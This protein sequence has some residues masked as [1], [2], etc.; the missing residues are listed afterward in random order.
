VNLK[1]KVLFGVFL[2]FLNLAAWQKDGSPIAT[3]PGDQTEPRVAIFGKDFVV[4]YQ[5]W[6]YP[7]YPKLRAAMVNGETGEKIWDVSVADDTSSQGAHQI[8][9]D[10]NGMTWI[11]FERTIAYPPVIGLQKLNSNGEK[12]FGEAGIN[13]SSDLKKKKN[14]QLCLDGSGEGCYV[15]WTDYR[16]GSRDVWA[17]RVAG[18]GQ[19]VWEKRVGNGGLGEIIASGNNAIIAGYRVWK[20]DSMG[21]FLWDSLGVSVAD[22]T[23]GI[24]FPISDEKQGVIV[25]FQDESLSLRVQR[26]DSTGERRWGNNG[27]VLQTWL[28]I[29]GFG[30]SQLVQESDFGFSKDGCGGCLVSSYKGIPTKHLVYRVDSSGIIVWPSGVDVWVYPG[31]DVG[32]SSPSRITYDNLGGCIATWSVHSDST[33]GYPG[34]IVAQRVDKE[35]HIRF[36]ENGLSLCSDSADQRNPVIISVSGG[37][38]LYW[39]D[40]RNGNTDI[41]AQF[42]DTL[43]NVGLE[44]RD[45]PKQSA[46][47]LS[48]NPN[49]FMKEVSVFYTIPQSSWFKLDIFDVAGRRVRVLEEG[50]K[51]AGIYRIRWNRKTEKGEIL[52]AGIYF[53]RLS[54]ETKVITNKLVVLG[55]KGV[56]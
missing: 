27:V 31:G 9:I 39:K 24:S 32:C 29:G 40:M 53:C 50:F 2:I 46:L 33:R 23:T 18:E 55:G 8:V 43:G 25:F 11:G 37:A 10:K 42:V 12:I 45:R 54:L 7:V 22:I 19:V 5:S 16:S 15:T 47:M 6:V 30:G 36:Q 41:Y 52:P 14:P 48:S 17:A 38:I 20:I 44:D 51:K 28:L 4:V 1:E 56:E 21:N 3:G 13:V 26:I 49:P 35:G 34:D